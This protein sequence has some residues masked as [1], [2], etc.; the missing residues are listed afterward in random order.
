ME[1]SDCRMSISEQ[2]M[3][4]KR[5]HAVKVIY[6]LEYCVIRIIMKT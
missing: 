1:G 3:N 5:K 4:Q 2:K 6:C